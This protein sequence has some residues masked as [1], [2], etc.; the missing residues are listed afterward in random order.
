MK[1]MAIKV[2]ILGTGNMGKVHAA[3]YQKMSGV[4]LV[5]MV[6]RDELK[7]KKVAAQFETT[8]LTNP[9]QLL[10]NEKVD[11]IDVCFPTALHKKYVLAALKADKHVLCEAPISYSLEDADEMINSSK[12]TS[13]FFGVA[14]LLPFIAERRYLYDLVKSK[15]Y[16]KATSV[17]IQKIHP[18]YW[19]NKSLRETHYDD[20]I[21][22]L[23]NFEFAYLTWLFGSPQ[24]V[25]AIG[26]K[27]KTKTHEH[28]LVSL[29]YDQFLASVEGNTMVSK[30][31]SL[32]TRVGIT[33]EKAFVETT[34]RISLKGG[35]PEIQT[36]LYP[37]NSAGKKV[38]L[39]GEDPYFA[40][41]KYFVQSVREKREPSLLDP[42]V[43][44]EALKICL[45]VNN[46]LNT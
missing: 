42:Q 15:K 3:A 36:F 40:E 38:E 9:N 30:D 34:T 25:T 22:E 10:Q 13:K 39:S 31:F 24:L 7:T 12:E 23:L 20:P 14:V 45:E 27:G 5:A 35:M 44:R 6:G 2:G 32:I 29:R 28:V 21:L 1:D 11:I 33:F 4:E 18:P 16:G 43:A 19:G 37:I 8:P 41:L 17:N 46:Y 26:T